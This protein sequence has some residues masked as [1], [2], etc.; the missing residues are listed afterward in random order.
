MLKEGL[1]KKKYENVRLVVRREFDKLPPNRQAT[2]KASS[3]GAGI[4]SP[5]RALLRITG[6][7]VNNAA[8]RLLREGL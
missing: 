6:Q 7:D 2:A 8:A 1:D 4:A 5:L 3:C